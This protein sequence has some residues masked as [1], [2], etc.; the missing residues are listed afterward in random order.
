MKSVTMRI[1]ELSRHLQTLSQPEYR[2]SVESAVSKNDEKAL[3]NICRKSKIPKAYRSS[4]VSIAL[5][6]NPDKFPLTL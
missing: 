6:V 5:S 4:I 1:S 2:D 3:L